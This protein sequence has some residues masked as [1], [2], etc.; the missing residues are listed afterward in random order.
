VYIISWVDEKM[1]CCGDSKAQE[2]EKH[3]DVDGIERKNKKKEKRINSYN[4]SGC[5]CQGGQ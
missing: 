1:H 2:K 4:V 5:R 3:D